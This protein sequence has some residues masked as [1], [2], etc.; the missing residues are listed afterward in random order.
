MRDRLSTRLRVLATVRLRLTLMYAAL[1][2]VGGAILLGLT[3]ILLSRALAPPPPVASGPNGDGSGFARSSDQTSGNDATSLEER[4]RETRREERESALRQVQVQAAIA[5]TA[6]SVGALVLGW[7]VSGRVLRPIRDITQHA[8]EANEATLD[9]RI[10]LRGP[11]DELKEL[12][13]TFDAMLGR[14]QSAFASQRRFAATVS[15]ELRTPLAIIGAE[16]DLTLAAP[17]VTPRETEMATAVRQATNRTE[18][19]VDGLLTLSR[20]ESTMRDDTRIDL[21]DL[22]G[23]VMGELIDR[24]DDLGIAVD[25]ELESAFVR[26]DA[27]LLER[28]IGNLVE[29]AIRYNQQGG[30]GWIRLRAGMDGPFATI[31][32]ENSG[33]GTPITDVDSL[34]EPFQRGAAGSKGGPRKPGGFGLGLAIVR[35]VVDT[36]NGTITAEGRAD[37][38]LRLRIHLPSAPGETPSVSGH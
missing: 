13:D 30:G 10:D 32:I 7:I 21:A 17:D 27:V 1:F 38:G 33:M 37:G 2:F 35:S 24:A 20:S 36:H 4:I 14:L 8:R 11:P 15:H 19:L 31:W 29:N 5:L 28:M 18:R 16:A 34:F 3:Y 6:T 9:K 26:G 22:A 12:A 23:D 25:L